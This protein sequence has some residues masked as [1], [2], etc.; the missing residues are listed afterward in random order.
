M[1][2]NMITVIYRNRVYTYRVGVFLVPTFVKT[3]K[4]NYLGKRWQ[5]LLIVPPT[6][7]FLLGQL[8]TL[9][10]STETSNPFDCNPVFFF[11]PLPRKLNGCVSTLFLCTV[12]PGF[13]VEICAKTRVSA[14]AIAFKLCC[15]Y[16][17]LQSQPRAACLLEPLQDLMFKLGILIPK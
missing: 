2:K 3:N 8:L 13:H 10:S 17:A 16:I 9:C 1:G 4:N 14:F 12:P 15:F 6:P 5:W 7:L 11:H